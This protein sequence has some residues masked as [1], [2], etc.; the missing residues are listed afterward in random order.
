MGCSRRGSKR[1][2]YS[3]TSLPQ[4]TPKNSNKQPILKPKATREKR[5][6][7]MQS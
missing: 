4:D 3:N 7:K 6:N 1:E 2:V 5:T